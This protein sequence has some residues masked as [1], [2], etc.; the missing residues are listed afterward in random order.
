VVVLDEGVEPRG[1]VNGLK[2]SGQAEILYEYSIIK[3]FAVHM[4]L[5]ALQNALKNIEGV[6]IY[7]NSVVTAIE[8]DSPV[9]SWGIDR[10]DQTTGR[11]N[12]YEYERDGDNV[13]VYILDTGIFIEHVDF[14]GRASHGYDATGQGNGDGNGHG[15][16]VAG[17]SPSIF[18]SLSLSL[19]PYAFF[20]PCDL[21][22][23]YLTLFMR[24]LVIPSHF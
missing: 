2:N 11:N 3:G 6:T 9:Y 7:P 17:T 8:V 19:L 10:V 23:R 24:V 22:F 1:L 13:D 14:G 16:H 21:R 12:Q 20:V 18:G 5:N 15:T 4:N